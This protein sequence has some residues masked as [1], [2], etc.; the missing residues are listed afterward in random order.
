MGARTRVAASLALLF[1]AGG[2][3]SSVPEARA[4][5]TIT[6]A[7][8]TTG[9]EQR[10]EIQVPNT[11]VNVPITGFRLTA[12][13]GVDVRVVDARDWSTMMEGSTLVWRD[14]SVDAGATGVFAFEADLPNDGTTIIFQGEEVYP[15]VPRSGLFPLQ[16]SLVSRSPPPGEDERS[17][18]PLIVAS[19]LA[20]ATLVAIAATGFLRRRDRQRLASGPP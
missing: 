14:G 15:S 19:V 11:S 6:P 4:H 17:L 5:G 10:F 8:A 18:A 20:I 9:T 3:I 13:A 12:P 7:E 2:L 1:A 16:V